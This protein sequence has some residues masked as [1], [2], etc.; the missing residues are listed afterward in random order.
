MR[1]DAIDGIVLRAW[2]S[3]EHDRYLS[4]L[5]ASLGR[6]TV[7]AKGSKSMRSEQRAVSQLYTY[8]NFEIYRRGELYI[9]KGGS[10]NEAFYELSKDIDR[11]NLAAY[12]CDA[13]SE[14]TDE[15]VD[16]GDILRLLLNSLYAICKE[17]YPFACIKGAFE[18]R[19]AFLSGYE[20]DLSACARCGAVESD[21]MYLDVMNG[22]LVCSSCLHKKSALP[23]GGGFYDEIREAEL[24]MPL[25]PAPLAAVRYLA[26]APAARI[27]SFALS[28]A[29]DL[30]LFAGCAET[31]LLSH[32]G[33]GFET[34]NFYHAMRQ[35]TKGN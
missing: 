19:A 31:Y 23:R 15:G 29:E 34:L 27:F 4:I 2:D 7:L 11:L 9:L 24:L 5:T 14:L 22:A 21:P 6:I 13:C 26:E 33:R 25:P 28:D 17:R 32:L 3:G 20:P 16:A 12:L 10:V 1:H 35:E 18:L 30:R 8:A